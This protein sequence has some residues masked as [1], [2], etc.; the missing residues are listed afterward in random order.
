MI[1]QYT[2]RRQLMHVIG[3]RSDSMCEDIIATLSKITRV[4]RVFACTEISCG[5]N[6]CL[7]N[8]CTDDLE[9]RKRTENVDNV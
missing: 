3:L 6:F 7:Y 5:L 8:V 1:V 9:L 2:V 4:V